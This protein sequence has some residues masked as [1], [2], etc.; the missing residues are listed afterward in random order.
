MS[1]KPLLFQYT[2]SATKC[3]NCNSTKSVKYLVDGKEMW[4]NVC[5]LKK[6][7]QN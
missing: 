5:V 6:I 2:K 1:K 4:C 3:N 7:L